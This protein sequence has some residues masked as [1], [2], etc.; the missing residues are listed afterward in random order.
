MH[1]RQQEQVCV[2]IQY[3][4]FAIRMLLGTRKIINKN[5]VLC[6]FSEF[7]T[8]NSKIEK[9]SKSDMY[10]ILENLKKKHIQIFA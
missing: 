4:K 7:V 6:G 10:S 3:I 1:A 8:A 5:W 2:Q 9:H